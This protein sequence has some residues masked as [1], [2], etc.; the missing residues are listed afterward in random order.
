MERSFNNNIKGRR[1]VRL[2]WQLIVEGILNHTA[3]RK[4][5]RWV[6]EQLK[7]AS[8]NWTEWLCE[9]AEGG[10]RGVIDELKDWPDER[11]RATDS[12]RILRSQG[13]EKAAGELIERK[14][15]FLVMAAAL[16]SM[17]LMDELVAQNTDDEPCSG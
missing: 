12:W 16:M 8:G 11:V 9:L 2:V 15:G 7:A 17:G 4:E 10:L 1:S 13:F 14:D 6:D 3:S 5:L